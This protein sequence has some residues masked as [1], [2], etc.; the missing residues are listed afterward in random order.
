MDEIVVTAPRINIGGA[1]IGPDGTSG[2]STIGQK[3]WANVDTGA[4]STGL[5][6]D[7][8]YQAL[9]Q[10]YVQPE[11]PIKPVAE[12][13]EEVRVTAKAVNDPNYNLNLSSFN[14]S[15]LQA[16]NLL[17]YSPNVGENSE[18]PDDL[19]QEL[20]DA[21]NEEQDALNPIEPG[22][23]EV[24]TDPL[25]AG[26]P[27]PE[28]A[29]APQTIVNPIEEIV[30]Y[31]PYPVQ[32]NYLNPGLYPGVWFRPSPGIMPRVA[33]PIQ[34]KWPYTNPWNPI[35][36]QPGRVIIKPR[37]IIFDPIA[38][39]VPVSPNR[40]LEVPL[41]P[42]QPEIRPHPLMRP[43]PTTPQPFTRPKDRPKPRPQKKED[44]NLDDIPTTVIRIRPGIDPTGNPGLEITIEPSARNNPK[45][46]ENKRRKDR[47]EQKS[48]KAY[49][50]VLKFIN[51][52][53]GRVTELLDL[54]SAIQDN[55]Y[56]PRGTVLRDKSGELRVTGTE[57]PMSAYSIDMQKQ[58]VEQLASNEISMNDVRIDADQIIMDVAVNQAMD[59]AIGKVSQKYASAL[60]DLGIISGVRAN[61]IQF[62]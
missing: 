11:T 13:I 2:Y 22:Y 12:P 48:Q 47:K 45:R 34:P 1:A 40:P 19:Y 5:D 29:P 16:L 37:P 15:R 36:V 54:I 10:S 4:W 51:N 61:P 24:P 57:L 55:I 27:V 28:Y 42:P 25:P 17:L 49:R 33:D 44:E 35:E 6:L 38:P 59:K 62:N 3:G 43:L 26:E 60:N 41:E 58:F 39:S 31:A 32:S 21:Y 53:F 14:W 30:I 56:V 9:E 23:E 18:L 20:T 8:Y 52:T 50:R 7:E 46:E